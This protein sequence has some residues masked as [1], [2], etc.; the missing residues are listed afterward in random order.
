MKKF[1]LKRRINAGSVTSKA[2]K[3]Q[4]YNERYAD[5]LI[6][7]NIHYPKIKEAIRE[8]NTLR[9]IAHWFVG[10]GWTSVSEAAFYNAL[11]GFRLRHPE[12]LLGDEDDLDGLISGNRPNADPLTEMNKLY[13]AQKKRIFIDLASEKRIGKLFSTM[14]DEMKVA[15][16]M[17]VDMAKI[18]GKY[19][20]SGDDN[21]VA[22]GNRNYDPDVR[23]DLRN[24]RLDEESREKFRNI[25]NAFLKRLGNASKN[26][27]TA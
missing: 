1:L 6:A 4:Q 21:A 5:K 8:G 11:T 14:N 27:Q 18:S 3:Q 24:I 20:G 7:G 16:E 15:K 12:M 13:R 10:S 9:E 19:S 22:G 23:D 2:T 17:V 25:S 26:T